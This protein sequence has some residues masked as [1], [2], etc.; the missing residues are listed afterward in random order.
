MRLA[1]LLFTLLISLSSCNKSD[2][3]LNSEVSAIALP[4]KVDQVKFV[5]PVVASA[6]EVTTITTPKI[7]KDGKLRFETTDLNTTYN[8]IVKSTTIN[9]GTI[10][11]DSQGKEYGTSYRHLVIRIPSSNFDIFITS[12][13]K[14]V[15]F[16]EMKEVTAEDVTA[17]FIDIDARLK[18]KKTLENRYLELLKKATKVTEML[19]IEKQLSAIREEIEAK[20]GELNYLQNQVTNSTVIIRFYKNEPLEDGATVS[21][22]SQIMTALSSGFNS[23]SGFFIW[24]L[25]LWPF[26]IILAV[27]LYFIRKKIKSKKL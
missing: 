24:L 4:Q 17:Q 13:S 26:I 11:Q 16:F 6:Q 1:T 18:A 25:S 10:Q 8:Q 20:Q 2:A 27:V 5:K 15:A 22:G 12:I 21:Y 14:G 9:G 19:E 3:V 23:F 7:I